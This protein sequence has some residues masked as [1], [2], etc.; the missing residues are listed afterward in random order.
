MDLDP[1]Y[2]DSF[3]DPLLRVT[4]DIP[5]HDKKVM[6]FSNGKMKEV[7]EEMGADIVEVD[8]IPEDWGHTHGVGEAGGGVIMGN[9]PAL[10]AVNHYSQGREKESIS[11]LGASSVPHRVPQR[12]ATIG[13]FAYRAAE[14][15]IQYLEEGEGL[16]V[17][18]KEKSNA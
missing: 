13:A 1:T 7:M 2:K 18:P 4:H 9:D 6:E 14:G 15:M 16:L 17:E 5:D 11:V 3:N 12:A 8:P 10:S